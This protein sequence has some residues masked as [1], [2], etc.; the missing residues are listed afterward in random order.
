V[1][2]FETRQRDLF[3]RFPPVFASEVAAIPGCAGKWYF[4]RLMAP[5]A[6]VR[7]GQKSP[8]RLRLYRWQ[9]VEEQPAMAAK[10]GSHGE[11][12]ADVRRL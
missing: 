2:A 6:A 1:R 11:A 7:L 8:T 9:A 5:L 10:D 12:S 3:A 4:N